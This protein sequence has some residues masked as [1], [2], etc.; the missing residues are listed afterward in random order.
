VLDG[1]RHLTSSQ[2]CVLFI[3]V[4]KHQFARVCKSWR[5]SGAGGEMS[6]LR[7]SQAQTGERS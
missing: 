5:H 2:K 7:D 6:G 3:V 1:N 4:I